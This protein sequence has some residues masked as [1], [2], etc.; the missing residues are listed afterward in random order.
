[1]KSETL[2]EVN[3]E[4]QA[5]RPV[6]VV[7]DM[8]DG[9]QRLVKHK[10]FASDPLRAELEKHLRMGKQRRGRVPHGDKLFITVHA[11]TAWPGLAWPGSTS[12]RRWRRWREC[13]DYDVT[14]VDPRTVF[15]SPERFSDV[16]LIAERPTSARCRRSTSTTDT[17]FVALTHDRRSTIRAAHA[18]ERDRFYIGALGSRKTHA[19]VSIGRRSSASARTRRRAPRASVSISAWCRGQMR[20]RSSA[21]ITEGAARSKEAKVAEKVAP[22]RPH[23]AGGRDRRRG[24]RYHPPRQAD[25]QERHP[26]IRL[27]EVE[28]LIGRRQPGRG[29][30]V[31]KGDIRQV[32]A[33]TIAEAAA[34]DG[35]DRGARLHRRSWHKTA[36]PLSSARIGWSRWKRSAT[37]SCWSIKVKRYSM[38]A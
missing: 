37:G 18:L 25:P 24:C 35:V 5:R 12:P 20:S 36:P 34:G 23:R 29:R 6:L 19:S 3:A 9:S 27:A 8:A 26:V 17:A 31:D 28:A 13:W 14:V 10:D 32:A 33:A 15:A 7:T 21:K 16:P 11:P 4:R 22:G 38:A 1:M 30:C 2:A